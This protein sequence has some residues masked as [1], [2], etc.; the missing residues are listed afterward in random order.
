MKENLRIWAIT[1]GTETDV[2]EAVSALYDLAIHSMDFGSGFWSA[3]DAEPV[4]LLARTCGFEGREELERYIEKD[5]I[6]QEK[7]AF[8]RDKGIYPHGNLCGLGPRV[9]YH[10]WSA[11]NGKCLWPYCKAS[12]A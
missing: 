5:R 4:A 3:E 6:L 9:H 7:A 12:K 10:E 8:R 2:T 11:I 1:D